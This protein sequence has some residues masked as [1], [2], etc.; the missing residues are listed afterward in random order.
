VVEFVGLVA[1]DDGMSGVRAPLVA[2]H[3]IELGGQQV[4]ELPL[5]FIPPLQTNHARTWHGHT[6][7]W[8]WRK[9]KHASLTAGGEQI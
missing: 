7:M 8:C 1:N 5:R 4:D 2:D 6:L 3:D 9:S